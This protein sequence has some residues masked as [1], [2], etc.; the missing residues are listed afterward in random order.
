MY[1]YFIKFTYSWKEIRFLL[2]FR[3]NK[4]F[5]HMKNASVFKIVLSLLLVMII[6]SC[7]RDKDASKTSEVDYIKYE[8]VYLEKM[9]GDIPT[10]V[11]PGEMQAYYDKNH[12]LTRI[13]GFFGQFSLVQ[14]ADLKRNTVV[15][16]LNFLGNKIYYTGKKGEIPAGIH[17]LDH[18][19]IQYTKDTMTI[20]GL[21]SY[22][23]HVQLSDEKY[24]IFYTKEISIDRPN[25]TTPYSTIDHV[26]CD[27][28][29]Q[30]SY[31]KMRLIIKDHQKEN[32]DPSIFEIPEDYKQVSKEDM[33]GIINSLFTKD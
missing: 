6:T 2:N 21:L 5:D 4:R 3:P 33:E 7:K 1:A 27:F 13:D 10:N 32:I 24:D 18:P 22:R 31:L 12:V 11:L 28:R 20:S 23:A 15:S 25:V 16:M 8:V 14:V 9:A 19:D 17:A 29:V 30:L 26:L